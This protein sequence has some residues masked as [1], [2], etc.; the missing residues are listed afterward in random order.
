MAAEMEEINIEY[1]YELRVIVDSLKAKT[2]GKA[3]S[4]TRILD[5]KTYANK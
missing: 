2:A 3:S 5:K 1:A 4:Q